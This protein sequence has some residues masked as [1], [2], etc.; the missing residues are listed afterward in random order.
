MTSSTTKAVAVCADDIAFRSLRKD[1]LAALQRGSAGAEIELLMRR[2]SVI[3]VHLVASKATTTIG[4]WNFAKSS[5]EG[6]SRS[7][8]KPHP[9]DLAFPVHRVV[10]DICRSLAGPR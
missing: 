4:A 1:L 8:P 2:I 7:L 6:R 10:A 3:E 5:Q 9:F